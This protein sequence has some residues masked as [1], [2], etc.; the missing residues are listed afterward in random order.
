MPA[1][2]PGRVEDAADGKYIPELAQAWTFLLV[3]SELIDAECDLADVDDAPNGED[4]SRRDEIDL[5]A[6]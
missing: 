6:V 4:I 3:G 1:E 5:E 2:K